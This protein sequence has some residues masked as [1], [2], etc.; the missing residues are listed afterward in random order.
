[1]RKNEETK[2]SESKFF[3]VLAGQRV[4][5]QIFSILGKVSRE[6]KDPNSKQVKLITA[7]DYRLVD[8][9]HPNDGLKTW[10][11][12]RTVSDDVDYWLG[13]GVYAMEV[14]RRG[15]GINDTKYYFTPLPQNEMLDLSKYKFEDTSNDSNESSAPAS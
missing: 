2:R 1:M 4:K 5:V 7:Y 3:K 15:S 6:I 10:S 13:K 11:V 12:S 9:E 8:L 14:E